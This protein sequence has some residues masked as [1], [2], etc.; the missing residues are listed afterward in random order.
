MN[1]PRSTAGNSRR[2]RLFERRNG[3][4]QAY[5][6]VQRL[7]SCSAAR[8]EA[9]NVADVRC[10]DVSRSGFSY[11]SEER[12]GNEHVVVDLGAGDDCWRMLAEVR[13]ATMVS[14]FDRPLHLVGCRILRRVTGE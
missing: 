6:Y 2:P 9:W 8:P 3:E 12:P 5:P 7:I 10:H 11:W 4:R 14:C 1:S 13:H